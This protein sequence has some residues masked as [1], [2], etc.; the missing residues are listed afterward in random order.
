MRYDNFK[1][2]VYHQMKLWVDLLF[3]IINKA[4]SMTTEGENT[5]VHGM[6]S[7]I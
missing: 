5:C 4:L 3:S 6:T 7:S 2:I 1:G